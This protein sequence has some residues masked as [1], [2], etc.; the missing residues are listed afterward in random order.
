M[1]ALN[2][3]A[4]RAASEDA[5]LGLEENMAAIEI[6]RDDADHAALDRV[7]QHDTDAG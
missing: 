7:G 4:A 6:E 2:S 1:D 3:E 5:H